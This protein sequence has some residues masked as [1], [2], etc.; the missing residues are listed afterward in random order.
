MAVKVRPWNE[1]MAVIITGEEMPSFVCA[2]LRASFMAASFASAPEL[3][4]KA[5]IITA[6]QITEVLLLKNVK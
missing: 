4:K 1:L 5:Y 3:Q 6:S 2:Y